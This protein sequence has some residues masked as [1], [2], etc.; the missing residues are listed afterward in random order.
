[1]DMWSKLKQIYGPPLALMAAAVPEILVAAGLFSAGLI[2]GLSGPEHFDF[3]QKAVDQLSARFRDLG[4]LAFI[5]RIFL[6]NLVA[7]YLVSCLI[8]LFG[9]VPAFSAAVNGLLVGWVLAMT[10]DLG[11]VDAFAGLAPHGVFELPAVAIAW[12]IGIWR[13]I[14]YRISKRYPGGRLQRWRAAN[15][16]FFMVVV[17]LLLAAA[18]VEGRLHIARALFS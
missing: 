2:A 1:M 11:I 14:G 9:V 5:L 15:R 3:L 12:G 10:P 18:I 17:P 13:G 6:N 16:V 7:T 4:P 8:V